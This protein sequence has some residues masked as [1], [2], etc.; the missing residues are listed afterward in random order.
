MGDLAWKY[1]DELAPTR[2]VLCPA[3]CSLV[4]GDPSAEVN[5]SFGC[6]TVLLVPD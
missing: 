4:Q 6:E 3:A 2:V 1:D 5:V